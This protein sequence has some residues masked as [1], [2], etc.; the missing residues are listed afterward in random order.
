MLLEGRTA[1]VTGA[2][3]GIGAAIARRFAAE[4]AR[5]VLCARGESV[6]TVAAEIRAHGGQ[7]TALRGDVRDEAFLKEMIGQ[8]RKLHG[9]LDV[10]VNNAGIIHRSRIGMTTGA[11]VREM[12]ETNVVAGLLLTQYAIRIMDAGRRPSIVNV[13]S[14]A[15]VGGTEGISAYSATKGAVVAFTRAAAK[16]LAG[17]GIRVNAI[18]PGMIDT[19]MVKS[20]SKEAHECAASSI[21]MGRVGTPEDV[22]GA[23]LFLASDLSSYVTGQVLGVD[24][25]MGD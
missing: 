7:A 10:L 20:L 3:R 5:L 8:C 21:R 13:A 14:V 4:G 1:L 15:G 25:G 9:T 24:G 17:S 18:A 11:Q 19:D 23:A 16:E 12:L 2:S 22:A 6:E